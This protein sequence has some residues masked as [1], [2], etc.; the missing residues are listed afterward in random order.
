MMVLGELFLTAL[1]A[2]AVENLFFTQGMGFAR[3]LHGAQK[4]RDIGLYALLLTGFSLLSSL[5]M[6]PLGNLLPTQE[7]VWLGLLGAAVM[8]ACYLLACLVLVTLCP[9]FYRK[10]RWCLA[11]AAINTVVFSLPFLGRL[12]QWNGW[13]AVGFALGTGL[14]FF[15]STWLLTEMLPRLRSLDMPASFRGMPGVFLYLAILALAL[16]GFARIS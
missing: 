6:I 7:F 12:H 14:A 8:A 11:P 9:G 15:L 10:V 2:L 13:Q 16:L 3:V 4:G 5:L 1:A